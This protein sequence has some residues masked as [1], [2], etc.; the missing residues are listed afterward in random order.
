MIILLAMF[1][2]FGF[3]VEEAFR[4][5]AFINIPLAI[6]TGLVSIGLATHRIN[7]VI[8]VDKQQNETGTVVLNYIMFKWIPQFILGL[9]LFFVEPMTFIGIYVIAY[10][11]EFIHAISYSG[12]TV[13]Y[14]ISDMCIAR[15]R[16]KQG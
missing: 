12:M 13:R 1:L 9:S 2:L 11:I 8:S 3:T 4:V 14:Y 15:I 10:L 7:E 6:V 5:V 16:S